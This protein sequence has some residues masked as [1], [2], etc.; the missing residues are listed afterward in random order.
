MHLGSTLSS[1]R[2]HAVCHPGE[3][4]GRA[5]GCPQTGFPCVISRTVRRDARTSRIKAGRRHA[6]PRAD[7]EL[8]AW[9]W[10]DVE[11]R[12]AGWR[13]PQVVGML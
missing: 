11:D 1:N 10:D 3:Q 12:I 6:G 8:G 2:G 9:R 7:V 5:F 4:L 13:S